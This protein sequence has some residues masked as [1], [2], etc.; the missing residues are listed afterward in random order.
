MKITQNLSRAF[1]LFIQNPSLFGVALSEMIL[2]Y[3]A[4]MLFFLGDMAILFAMNK[5]RLAN[6]PLENLDASLAAF[7]NPTTIAVFLLLL[8]IQGLALLLLDSFFKSGLYG[9][10][11]NAIL[12]GS[13]SFA[14]FM[15]EAKRFWPPMLRFLFI[16]YFLV[17]LVLSPFI[18]IIFRLMTTPQTSVSD[19]LAI[20]SLLSMTLSFFLWG[21]LSFVLLYGEAGVVLGRMT[22]FESVKSS[23]STIKKHF[24][25]SVL[26]GLLI[27]GLFLAIL[28]FEWILTIPINA[29]EPASN[30]FDSGSSP[31]LSI[32]RMTVSFFSNLLIL[33]LTIIS[34]LLIFLM[35]RGFS[36]KRAEFT[37]APPA[38]EKTPST[39]RKKNLKK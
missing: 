12:D 3:L 39:Q 8:F 7:M 18:F 36:S 17:I 4:G 5:D 33:S 11:K 31:A 13:T 16:K 6:V 22:A 34:S 1:A 10:M 26:L 25:T 9:M 28:I 2:L 19:S 20:A 14:E 32:A 38:V 24:L 37:S 23:V 35:Y 21:V 27:I 15:P 30:V 29:Q